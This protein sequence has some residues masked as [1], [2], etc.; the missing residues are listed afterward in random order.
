MECFCS[1]QMPVGVVSLI[2][3]LSMLMLGIVAGRNLKFQS[4]QVFLGLVG[5][6]VLLIFGN[7][8][9]STL[10]LSG[11][12][13]TLCWSACWLGCILGQR[14][15]DQ[16]HHKNDPQ[17]KSITFW[18]YVSTVEGQHALKWPCLLLM[19]LTSIVFITYTV[20]RMSLSARIDILGSR[21]TKQLKDHV[22][23]PTSY[24]EA[25]SENWGLSIQTK[26]H[27]QQLINQF[28]YIKRIKWISADGI[29]Q[30]L[31]PKQR[32]SLPW[33][34]VQFKPLKTSIIRADQK[35]K[36]TRIK[37]ARATSSRNS[38]NHLLQTFL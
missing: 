10:Q 9:I 37:L 26:N 16:A 4:T 22:R 7:E 25:I 14:G 15:H 18:A 30:W 5:W 31:V 34:S 19:G 29:V 8:H 20:E 36:A 23:L 11:N 38:R 13:L 33:Q 35:R 6:M 32:E 3:T 24:I 1:L 28:P 27:A 12:T 17:S 21:L 2:E